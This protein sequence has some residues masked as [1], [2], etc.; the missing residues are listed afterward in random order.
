M[1]GIYKITNNAN[2]KVYIGQS[3][4]IDKRV[5]THKRNIEKDEIDTKFYRTLRKHGWENFSVEV[6][7]ECEIVELDGREKYWIKYYNS[8]KNGY[9]STE[10]GDF[11]PSHYPEL[12]EKRTQTLLNNPE[13]N[14]KLSLKGEDNPRALLTTEDVIEIRKDYKNGVSFADSYQ[15]FQDKITKSAFQYC[16]LGK[17]WTE[18][19]PEVFEVKRKNNGGSS[20]TREE[21]W[22]LRLKYMLGATKEE[23]VKEFN[24]TRANLNRILN[25]TRWKY[26]ESIPEGYEEFI[27]Q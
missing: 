18:I 7:E 19:M 26:P 3:V 1:I 9:N 24:L 16:W 12:V 20:R 22:Q 21:I 11:N 23:L 13:V 27:T 4:N 6:I 10:G 2:N 5:A 14:K 15:K 25:L 17:T 8:Y